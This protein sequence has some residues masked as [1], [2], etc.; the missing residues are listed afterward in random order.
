MANDRDVCNKSVL[1]HLLL[2]VFVN[3]RDNRR[4]IGQLNLD[5]LESF[6]EDRFKNDR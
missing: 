5:S 2:K 4:G 6:T 3:Y 1:T